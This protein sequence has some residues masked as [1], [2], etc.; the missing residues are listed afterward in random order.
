MEPWLGFLALLVKSTKPQFEYELL[1]F[2]LALAKESTACVETQAAH[3]WES[4]VRG[5]PGKT[6]F[7]QCWGLQELG[8][9]GGLQC[10]TPSNMHPKMSHSCKD[11]AVEAFHE[12]SDSSA[13][14]AD[15]PSPRLC[16]G[17]SVGS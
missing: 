12:P 10:S 16:M 2:R 15:S 3:P 5:V 4:N 6:A 9:V 1:R 11:R 14:G 8:V 13:M 17:L 7:Q